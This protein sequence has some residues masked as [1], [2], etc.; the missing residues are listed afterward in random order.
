[1]ATLLLGTSPSPESTI[2]L[3]FPCSTCP[4]RATM[5]EA[6]VLY[7]RLSPFLRV[8][9]KNLFF[10][11]RWDPLAISRKPTFQEFLDHYTSRDLLTIIKEDI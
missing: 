3:C 5:E 8:K 1:M 9:D 2:P 10:P 6:G 11:F 4:T 7:T